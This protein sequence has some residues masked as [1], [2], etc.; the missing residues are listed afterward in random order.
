MRCAVCAARSIPRERRSDLT[1]SIGSNRQVA[2]IAAI[3]LLVTLP[4]HACWK[5]A[6]TRY[7]VSPQLLYAI[8]RTES[9]LN[10]QAIGRNRNGSRDIGLMQIN[11]LSSR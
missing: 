6:G 1:Q 10:P 4:A 3:G 8:A 11:W 9:G 5:E 7:G 2:W